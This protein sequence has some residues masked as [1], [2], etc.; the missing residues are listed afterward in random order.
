MFEGTVNFWYIIVDIRSEPSGKNM[1]RV[2]W[3]IEATG[4]RKFPYR[5]TIKSGDEP[6]LCL[7]TQERWPGTKGHVFCVREKGEVVPGGMREIERVP[8]L[9]LRRFGKRL[10]V[11]LDRVKNKRCDFLFLEK[12]YRTRDGTYEQIFWRTEKA[13][14]ERKPRVKLSTYG[15][16]HLHIAIDTNERYPWR[17]TGCVVERERLPVGDYALKDETGLL[18][19]VERKTFDNILHEFGRMPAFHQQLSELEAYRHSALVI[20]ANYS[21]FLRPER[22]RY[23]PP[24]FSIKAI[25]EIFSY[26]PELHVV[27]AGNRKL[28]SEWTLRFFQAIKVNEEDLPPA[29]VTETV[30]AYSGTPLKGGDYY[31]V[32]QEIIAMP[33]RFTISMIRRACPD[34]PDNLIRRVL[35]DMK[36]EGKIVWVKR[37]WEKKRDS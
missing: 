21:D 14:K 35:R 12:R 5:L 34:V 3:I 28:A 19:V 9:S 23:Y 31:T 10:V 15:S 26:H 17:F 16:P 22:L 29:V 32:R 33:E 1:S 30:R 13:L 2:F 25:A 24:S 20:E 7:R 27:F 6:L 36:K 37:T 4:E 8:V 11:V 18:A